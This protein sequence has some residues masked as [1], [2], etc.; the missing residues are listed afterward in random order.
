MRKTRIRFAVC[1]IAAFSLL[2]AGCQGQPRQPE[3]CEQ[4]VVAKAVY[5]K[6]GSSGGGARGGSFGGGSRGSTP[7][8][9]S[10][11]PHK[12]PKAGPPIVLGDC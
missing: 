5:V 12:S 3:R 2:A 7:K 11:K 9:S 1:A 8:P 6:G 10:P 4:G